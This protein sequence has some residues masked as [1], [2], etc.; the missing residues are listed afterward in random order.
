MRRIEDYAL[1]SDSRSA[2]LVSLAG[3]ID[4]LCFPRFDSGACFASLLGNEDNGHWSLAPMGST[5]SGA[6]LPA[7]FARPRDGA[8]HR[9]R[10]RGGHRC[11]GSC[12]GCPPPG[13]PG[14]RS[15]W[16]GLDAQRAAGAVRL[17]Q[18]HPVGQ[19]ARRRLSAPLPGRKASFCARRS[20]C[21]ARGMPRSA[22]SRSAPGIGSASIWPGIRPIWPAPQPVD[23]DSMLD[24][25]LEWWTDWSSRLSYDGAYRGDVHESLTVLKG[26]SHAR[27]RIVR[28]GAPRRRFPSGSAARA[29]GT[30]AT[31][32]CATPPSHSWP[33]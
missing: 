8:L 24:A 22:S 27:D 7:R 12:R 5:R 4:W 10:C 13:A 20:R 6:A 26:L 17:R 11:P 25:T 33:C 3:S 21:T 31:A 32:G 29:T 16:F 9:D 14:R 1:L 30:T 2:A 15:Q 18:H 23:V 28:G 19:S